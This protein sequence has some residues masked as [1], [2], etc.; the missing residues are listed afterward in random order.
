M[1]W[2][3][4]QTGTLSAAQPLSTWKQIAVFDSKHQL[5]LDL[6]QTHGFD[7]AGERVNA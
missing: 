3:Q 1:C 4:E 7:L 6:G 2:L 5:R